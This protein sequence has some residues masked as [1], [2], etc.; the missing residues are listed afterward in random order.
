MAI[1][2]QKV[3]N[4]QSFDNFVELDINGESYIF[5]LVYLRD[6]CTSA[7]SFHAETQQRV[8]DIFN[9]L[10]LDQDLNGNVSL[11]EDELVI[12]WSNGH[13]S[14]F[15][16][17]WLLRHS[18]SGEIS[19]VSFPEKITW[20]NSSFHKLKKSNFQNDYSKINEASVKKTIFSEIFQY[21]FTLIENVPVTLEAT[22]KVSELISIVRPTHYDLGIWDFTSD[23]SKKDTAYTTLAID[24]HTDG[25]YWFEPPGLQLFHLLFHDGEG[26]ETRI[27]D[28]AR[29]VE[30]L[31]EKAKHDPSWEQTLRI[32]TTERLQFHQSGEPENVFYEDRF[33]TLTLDSNGKLF[34]CRWN[35]SD[36]T[37]MMKNTSYPVNEIYRALARFNSLINDEANF[38]KFPLRP[39]TILVF[40][41]WRVL[42]ART[43]FNGKRRLCGSYLTR[44]DFIARYR[45]LIFNREEWLD[46]V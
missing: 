44:D 38:V 39:G 7:S 31:Q 32:L 35:T 21:G 30:L 41:N 2:L 27:C 23:L 13:I 6:N 40:D 15:D 16:E 33:P 43:A 11:Q 9:E 36:R 37:S 19:K 5:H 46:S 28:V 1:L 42:H 4:D 34:Q 12:E 45:T 24:M 8:V 18:Y 26:G 29:V 20:N 10:N 17:K 14:K 22:Q 3:V 25:N